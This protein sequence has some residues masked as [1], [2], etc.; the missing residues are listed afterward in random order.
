MMNFNPTLSVRKDTSMKHTLFL[1]LAILTV[2]VSSTAA[3]TPQVQARLV[4]TT[5][6][7]NMIFFRGPI[8]VQYQ[9]TITNPGNQPLTLSRLNLSTMGPGG[10]RLHTGN[11]VVKAV[12]PANGSVTLNLSAWATTRGGPIASTQPVEMHGTLW[13]APPKGK[14]FVKSFLQYIPQL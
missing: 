4:Q 12:V 6:S 7:N 8:N 14:A 13:L 9:L 1:A 3:S 11:A 5:T 10:Y 2:A